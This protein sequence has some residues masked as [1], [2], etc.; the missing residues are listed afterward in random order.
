MQ[1]N[2]KGFREWTSKDLSVIIDNDVYKENE[3]IDY[4]ENFAVL[5]CLD[6]AQKKKKQDEFRHDVCSFANANGG[7]LIFGIK[8]EAG[9]PKD[10]LGVEIDNIDRFELD[11]RNELFGIM[12]IVPT[13]EFSFI[14][15]KNQRYVVIIKVSKGSHKPYIYVENE[16]VFKFFIRRGNR[17][18]AMSYMEISSNFLHSSLFTDEIRKF[19]KE[20]MLVYCCPAN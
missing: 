20:K 15:L 14:H 19:R 12:P 7:Y 17:K 2:S 11:R 6:K 8:E 18:Q 16:G 1:I 5:E 9:V 10:I 4:K 13:V 3:F